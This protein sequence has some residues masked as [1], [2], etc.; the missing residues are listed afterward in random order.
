MLPRVFAPIPTARAGSTVPRIRRAEPEAAHETEEEIPMKARRIHRFIVILVIVLVAAPALAGE[1]L[2]RIV[3]R[4]EIRVGMS[5]NQPPLNV[6]SKSGGLIGMEVDLVELLAGSMGVKAT[7][8]Q[9]PFGELLPA[10]LKGEVDMVVSGV[11]ITPERNTKVAFVGPYA[12][13]GKS[14]L[15]KSATLDSLDE[16]GEMNRDKVRLAALEGSTSQEFVEQLIP[17]ATLRKTKNYDEALKLLMED[18]VDAIVADMEACQFAMLRNPDAGLE[19]LTEPLTLEPIGMAL[20]PNDPLLINLVENYF[21]TIE[22][23]GLVEP[24][25]EKWYA[26]GAWLFQLP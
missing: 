11:T 16:A 1:V 13:T 12:I 8:V 24:L 6:K 19:T 20:P 18:Q 2:D 17:K 26:N 4:G 22:L 23:T 7:I 21:G 5:G 9:K 10:L 15:T 25:H 3:E 14:I